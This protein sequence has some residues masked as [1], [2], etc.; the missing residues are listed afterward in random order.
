MARVAK[1]VFG[2]RTSPFCHMCLSH[3]TRPFRNAKQM[4]RD[5]SAEPHQ[6]APR[7]GSQAFQKPFSLN[8]SFLSR[9]F[10]TARS[11]L[12]WLVSVK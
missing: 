4:A 11:M 3:T 7:T 1:N 12:A 5:Q 6:E 10:W 2:H 8:I 9:A